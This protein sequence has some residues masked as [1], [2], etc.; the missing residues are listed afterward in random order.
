MNA[1]TLCTSHKYYTTVHNTFMCMLYAQAIP[2]ENY[3]PISLQSRSND[4][5]TSTKIPYPF[6]EL[7]WLGEIL[8]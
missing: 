1:A 8:V 2:D 3:K 6:M 7:N 4:L 5:K